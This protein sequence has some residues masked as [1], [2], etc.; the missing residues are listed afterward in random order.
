MNIRGEYF[1]V[2]GKYFPAQTVLQP[3]FK[4]QLKKVDQVE[5]VTARL[6]AEGRESLLNF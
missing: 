3:S 6:A 1:N 4:G 2:G 5:E